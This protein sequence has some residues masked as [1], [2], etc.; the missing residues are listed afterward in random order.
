MMM[1]GS[2]VGWTTALAVALLT[3]TPSMANTA[4][5]CP[6]PCAGGADTSTCLRPACSLT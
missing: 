6:A 2:T 3:V 4:R 1:V 5:K